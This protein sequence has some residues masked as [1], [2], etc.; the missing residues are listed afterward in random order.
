MQILFLGDIVGRSGRSA[1]IDKIGA[2]RDA[3]KLDFVVVNGENASNGAGLTKSHAQALLGAGVDC[4]TLGDHAFDQKD[5]LTF[6]EEEPR[7]IRPI[8]FA[9]TAPGR[10]SNVKRHVLS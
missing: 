7:I 1:V 4:L 9:K 5:M 2:L 6:I 3:W 8:N 10:G